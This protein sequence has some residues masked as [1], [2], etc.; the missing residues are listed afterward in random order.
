MEATFLPY[1]GAFIWLSIL[2]TMGTLLRA[3]IKF[4]QTNL[5]PAALIGGAL[6]FVCVQLD[7]VGLPTSNGWVSIPTQVFS[8]ITFHLFAFGF[9][10]V[11]FMKSDAANTN[12][13]LMRGGI[14]MTFMFGLIWALQGIIGFSVFD[15]YAKITG[16]DINAFQGYLLG[17]G[18]AQGPGQAHAY[19]VIFEN[20]FG[21]ANSVSVGLATAALGFVCAVA[22][23]VPLAKLGINRGW[24]QSENKGVLPIDF[25]R[26]MMNKGDNPPCAHL[27]THPANV[28][29]LGFHVSIMAITYAAAYCFALLWTMYMPAKI[30]GLGFGILFTW[31]MCI[32]MVLRGIMGKTGIMHIMDQST[33]KRITNSSVDFMICAVFLA[34]SV[35]ELQN[36][37]IPLLSS[38]VIASIASLVVI[39]WFAKRAPGFRFERGLAIFGCYTGTVASGLLLLRIVDPEYK[40]PV[41]V[42]L[43]IMNVLIL[44]TC[45]P[46]MVG[47]ALIPEEGFPM[48]WIA[49]AYIVLTPLIMYLTK[50]I[51]KPSWK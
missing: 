15:L 27:T 4:F 1:V 49:L 31:G 34:I 14:W 18:F 42:E 12:T 47:Y 2:L 24:I 9:V 10:G 5:I 3:K 38:A 33:I 40:S 44:I 29:S 43:G 30:S 21:I 36:V 7:I 51:S 28:D 22:I 37:V 23:G 45:Q 48:F 11:G 39:L 41:A 25:L 16:A 13:V 17:S 32:A 8:V 6:G 19:G 50:F 26:G 35:A 20:N 46:L